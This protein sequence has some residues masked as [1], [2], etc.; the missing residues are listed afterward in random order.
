M[1]RSQT[2]YV[3]HAD[4]AGMSST[5]RFPSYRCEET[6]MIGERPRRGLKHRA[7]AAFALRP[8]LELLEDRFLLYATT[9]MQWPQP[10]LITYSFVPDGTNIGGVPSNL[11]Q[12]LNA[13]FAT[14]DWQAQFSKAASAWQK[15]ANINFTRVAD[16]GA[17][18]GVSGNMQ[19]DPRFGDIR[20]GGYAMT[21]SILAFAFLPPPA[22]GGTSAGDIFFNTNMSWQLNATT[23]DLMTVAIHEFGH[24][25]GM[26]HSASSTAAMW[27]AYTGAKQV[28][29]TDDTAGIRTI[30]NSRQNDFFDANGTND[31]ASEA[32]N[33][34]SY[35]DSNGQLTLSALDSTT[36]VM[37]GSNDTDWYRI[38]VPATTTGTMVVRM[39][40]TNLSLLSPWLAVYNSA[41]TT[42]LGQA[43]ST[44]WGDTVTVTINNVAAGQ[45]YDIRSKGATSGDSGFGSYGLQ[46]N[47]GSQVQDP[48]SSPNTTMAEQTDQGGG[49]LAESSD[50]SDTGDGTP[51]DESAIPGVPTFWVYADDQSVVNE[52]TGAVVGAV[53]GDGSDSESVPDSNLPVD[54]DQINLGNES[55]LGD[56]LMINVADAAS[57]DDHT[58]TGSLPWTPVLLVPR[59]ITV[60]QP[61]FGLDS[62]IHG[63]MA[64]LDATLTPNTGD[65]LTA[66]INKVS[67]GPVDDTRLGLEGN[68]F[69]D[70]GLV[71]DRTPTDCSLPNYTGVDRVVAAVPSLI[72]AKDRC[73]ESMPFRAVDVVLDGWK[74]D[75]LE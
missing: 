38:T 16:N 17:P 20:I 36:P 66:T 29:S 70:S 46:V 68:A 18:L 21:G 30:Y 55:G 6:T 44:A 56:A 41:G 58:F 31:L 40:S 51:Q 26:N 39:Q 13:H 23:Y 11:Q 59:A 43:S 67:A 57:L 35:I 19:S 48:V 71:A 9:G 54:G 63:L 14:A 60:S 7:I 12:T 34:S 61:S 2:E 27:P 4:R 74:A 28:L 52:D 65:T 42:M 32:D 49:T 10:K 73:V 50:G 37:I 75:L 33:I 25:L 5:T 24:A 3:Q 8:R 69:V 62:S 47:F 72:N 15:L 1:I 64:P 22:N 45:V 53:G